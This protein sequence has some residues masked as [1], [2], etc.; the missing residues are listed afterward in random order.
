MTRQIKLAFAKAGRFHGS[1]CLRVGDRGEQGVGVLPRIQSSMLHDN[2]DIRLD[3]ACII[4][5]S[6]IGA[7][8]SRSLNLRCFARFAGTMTRYGPTDSRS[9]K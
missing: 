1:V 7:G 4:G 5:S 9:E 6:R 2:R 3:H 8:S